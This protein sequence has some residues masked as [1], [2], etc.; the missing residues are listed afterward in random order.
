MSE[1]DPH[2]ID[3]H[4][5]GAKLDEGKNRLGLVFGGFANA[6]LGVGKVGTYG[7]LK[8]TDNGW[9]EV[10][11]AIERY[12]DALLRHQMAL[13]A[14]ETIDSDSGLRHVDQVSWNALAI[15]ELS[16]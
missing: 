3:Q 10:P 6:L 7:S 2:N 5:P 8:Y 9:C 14:G 16:D 15:A 13:L 4:Q 12:T 11:D 1:K